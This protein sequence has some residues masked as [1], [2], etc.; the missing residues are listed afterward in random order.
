MVGGVDGGPEGVG[1]V[2]LIHENSKEHAIAELQ[3][4][5]AKSDCMVRD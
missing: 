2:K 1:G 3:T 4:S 5:L